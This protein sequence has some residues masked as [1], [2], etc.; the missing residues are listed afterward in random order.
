MRIR[1]CASG[2]FVTA[3]TNTVG[4]MLALERNVITEHSFYGVEVE[5]RAP[6]GTRF[7]ATTSAQMARVRCP[8]W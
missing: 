8:T 7:S 5:V 3:L 1:R 2:V 6:R 4:E